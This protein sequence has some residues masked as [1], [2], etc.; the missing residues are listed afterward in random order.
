MTALL[1]VGILAIVCNGLVV[2]RSILIW[3]RSNGVSKKN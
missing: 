2:Y 1:I 3:R